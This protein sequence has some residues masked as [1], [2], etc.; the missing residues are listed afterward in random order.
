MNTVRPKEILLVKDS[1]ID[2]ML[3]VEAF[4][5]LTTR[6]N[7]HVVHDGEEAL[8]FLRRGSA[9]PTSPP[10]G[11]WILLDVNLPKIGGLEVLAEIKS[12]PGLERIPVVVLTTSESAEDIERAYRIGAN[13]YISKPVELDKFEE[14][15]KAIDGFW[16]SFVKLPD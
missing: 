11:I 14:A 16:L 13:C 6:Y 12:D 4:K 9:H 15:I 10:T 7:L 8:A 1:P 3:T 5:N 2:V